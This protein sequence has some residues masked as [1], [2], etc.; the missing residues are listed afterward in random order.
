MSAG[1]LSP[2]GLLERRE[3]EAVIE[4]LTSRLSHGDA[5]TLLTAL[6]GSRDAVQ[7]VP[8]EIQER[9]QAALLE[10]LPPGLNVV[11]V[12]KLGIAL[13]TDEEYLEE[14]LTEQERADSAFRRRV[15]EEAKRRGIQRWLAAIRLRTAEMSLEDAA[16]RAECQPTDQLTGNEGRRTTG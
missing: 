6:S 13:R 2:L 7:T 16:A 12:S 4:A 14:V 3:R 8:M 11:A 9:A 1:S 15:E 10:T 5:V